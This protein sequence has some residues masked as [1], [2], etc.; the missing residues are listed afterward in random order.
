MQCIYG[1]DETDTACPTLELR[2]VETFRRNGGHHYDGN[3]A[4][5]A[6][7]ILAGFKQR[8]GLSSGQKTAAVKS[9]AVLRA[10]SSPRTAKC[11]IKFSRTRLSRGSIRPPIG[12]RNQAPGSTRPPPLSQSIRERPARSPLAKRSRAD[13]WVPVAEMRT[14]EP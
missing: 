2:G 7:L 10:R 9:G 8:A 3:Y 4:A 11:A 5:L 12:A 1:Q 13:L 6:E 14:A